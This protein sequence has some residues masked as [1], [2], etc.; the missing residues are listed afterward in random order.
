MM[1]KT[2]REH[3]A[4]QMGALVL[5]NLEQAALIGHLQAELEKFQAKTIGKPGAPVAPEIDHS[6]VS[7]DF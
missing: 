1:V 5:A 3:I 6:R 7:D 2:A 4:E